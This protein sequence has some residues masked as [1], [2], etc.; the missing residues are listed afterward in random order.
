MVAPLSPRRYEIR[1]T[2]GEETYEALVRLQDLLSHQVPDRDPAT[3]ISRALDLLLERTLAR[4]AAVTDRPR[5]RAASDKRTRHIP[6]AVRRAVWQRDGGA[7]AFVDGGGRRCGSSRFLEFHHLRNW[8][9]GASHEP[10]EIELR[11]RSH[12]QH[13][14]DL[15]DGVEFVA[16]KKRGPSSRAKEPRPSDTT[17]GGTGCP[18]ARIPAPAAP[19]RI[20]APAARSRP[21]SPTRWYRLEPS[22]TGTRD[23]R[24]DELHPACARRS[25]DRPPGE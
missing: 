14:A 7:C 24:T 22:C 10:D 19:H 21:A 9:R 20:P 11:C 12:N 4:K 3:I 23:G 2:V 6:A 5:A 16:A 18:R 13:Q 15:D 8:A 1:V 17:A 25:C